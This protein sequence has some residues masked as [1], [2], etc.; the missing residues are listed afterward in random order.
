LPAE[1]VF[2]QATWSFYYRHVVLVHLPLNLEQRAGDHLVQI[3]RLVIGL[4]A[5][6][7]L[8][9]RSDDVDDLLGI[10]H[11]RFERG[12]GPLR[13][14]GPKLGA[15]Q[16]AAGRSTPPPTLLIGGLP[17]ETSQFSFGIRVTA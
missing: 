5:A 7:Q 13:V 2:A 6:Q 12:D 10:G 8:L 4:D 17:S 16:Q 3:K 15:K 1:H 11:D 9:D 14:G